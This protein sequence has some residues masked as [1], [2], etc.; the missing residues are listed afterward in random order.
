M[1]NRITRFL[2]PLGIDV[3]FRFVHGLLPLPHCGMICGV[4][5]VQSLDA[6][7]DLHELPTV[8]TAK[9]LDCKRVEDRFELE[10]AKDVLGVGWHSSLRR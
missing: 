2:A 9:L 1:R 7:L 5:H 10:H 4:G 8:P 3:G 6:R